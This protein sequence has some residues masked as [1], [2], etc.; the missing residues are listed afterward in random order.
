MYYGKLV[1]FDGKEHFCIE[2]T[3]KELVIFPTSGEGIPIT[4]SPSL[5]S[6][7]RSLSTVILE[8]GRDFAEILKGAEIFIAEVG[9]KKASSKKRDVEAEQEKATLGFKL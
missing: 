2:E 8:E 7:P 6:E 5:V 1:T 3:D 9:K 4:V